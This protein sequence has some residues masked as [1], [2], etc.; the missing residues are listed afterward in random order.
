MGEVPIKRDDGDD[1]LGHRE[2]VGAH[3]EE[4][5]RLQFDFLVDQGLGR[6]HTL[7]DVGCGSLRAGV[8]LIPHLRRGRY[9]GID[10]RA[11][12]IEAGARRELSLPL[13]WRKRPQLVVSDRFEFDLFDRPADVGIAQSLFTH[14]T[15]DLIVLCLTNL[16]AWSPACRLYATF[17]EADEPTANPNRPND[18]GRFAYTREEMRALAH[19]GGWQFSY[20]GE[21]GHPRGQMMGAFNS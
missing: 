14:L 7:V 20:I 16:R 15:P 13:R 4:I 6:E 1:T 11:D 9:L 18:H 8:W 3:W 2:Y 5:G 17:F 21:W 19:Q 12:L 10:K